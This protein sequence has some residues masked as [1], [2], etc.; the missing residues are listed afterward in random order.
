[1]QDLVNAVNAEIEVKEGGGV[2]TEIQWDS[3]YFQESWVRNF[4]IDYI[5]EELPSQRPQIPIAAKVLIL[6]EGCDNELA[7]KLNEKLQTSGSEVTTCFFANVITQKLVPD[8]INQLIAIVPSNPENSLSG[9]SK[10]RKIIDRLQAIVRLL[11]AHDLTITFMQFGGGDFGSKIENPDIQQCCTRAFAASFHLERPGNK[12]QVLDFAT[13][14]PVQA[15]ADLVIQE[16]NT[17]RTYTVAGYNSQ[18]QRLLPMHKVQR[19]VTIHL[20]K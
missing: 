2:D 17:T 12:V 6:H 5:P 19:T 11:P 4:V 1:M 3:A 8:N 9:E 10:V 15:I 14:I 16:C 18:M 7:T 20:A 13:D